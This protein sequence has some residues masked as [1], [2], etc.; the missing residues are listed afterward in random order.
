MTLDE[1]NSLSDA[2]AREELARCCGATRWVDGM[3]A[4]RPY[5]DREAVLALADEIWN[6]LGEADFREAFTHH[7]KI[8]DMEGLRKKFASTADLAAGEQSGSVGASE[9]ALQG[10]AQ[11]NRD[12]E[13]TY[14]F[15]FIVFATG[16]SAAEML[17]ILKS[18]LGNPPEKEIRIAAGE[19]AKITRNRIEKLLSE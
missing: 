12:Y 13:E 11:G 8:G 4:R 16:K 14:G 9:E 17:D 7:P 6:G 3:L 1:L 5:G 2:R 18:R 15:I 19:Q 10:L